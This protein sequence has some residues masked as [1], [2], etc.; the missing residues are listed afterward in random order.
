MVGRLNRWALLLIRTAGKEEEGAHPG[1][2]VKPRRGG[3]GQLQATVAR[4]G[5]GMERGSERRSGK[6]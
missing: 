2:R 6:P 5:R 1:E 4:A 3:A